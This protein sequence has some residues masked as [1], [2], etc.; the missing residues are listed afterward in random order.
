MIHVTEP[1]LYDKVYEYKMVFIDTIP[2]IP[3]T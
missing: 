3:Q 1:H 2:C